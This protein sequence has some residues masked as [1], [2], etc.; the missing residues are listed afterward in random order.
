MY[1]TSTNKVLLY[2]RCVNNRI[3]FERR[4][5]EGPGERSRREKKNRKIFVPIKRASENV[6]GC[7]EWKLLS[8][9][10]NDDC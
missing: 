6:H 4:R 3:F 1:Y 2:S 7:L 10:Y 5:K 9:N 8:R